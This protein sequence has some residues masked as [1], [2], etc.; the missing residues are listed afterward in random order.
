MRGLAASFATKLLRWYDRNRR[1]LP[2]R[3][4]VDAKQPPDPYR[5]MISEAMLQ[6]TQVAAV[7]P[8]FLRFL[9]QFPTVFDLAKA[10]DQEVLRLWQGL[11]YYS[12]ARN[13]HAAAK[14][15][16]DE[17]AGKIPRSPDVLLSL[18]G[19]GKYTAGAIASIAFD[20][21]APILDGNVIRVLCRLDRIES[22]PRSTETQKRLWQRAEEILPKRRCGDFNSALMELGATICT[23]R[24]PKCLLCP[25]RDHCQA[26]A[27]S[28]QEQI[29]APRKAT[30]TPLFHRKI[31]CIRHG[32]SFLIEQRPPKGRWA[33]MWQFVT[34][35]G[36][37]KTTPTY[38]K[39]HFAM[40]LSVVRSLG[41]VTHALTHRRYQFEAFI[42]D[43]R[44]NGKDPL[45]RRWATL[46]QLDAFPL[47][48]PHL[49]VAQ[50]LRKHGD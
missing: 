17:H 26:Q 30:P 3:V 19:V 31:L 27:A 50:M 15:I 28:V 47:P 24:S 1:D 22:D 20:C 46:D 42:C 12:R 29:P 34:L 18:P 11:G 43:V 7:I 25:V 37:V 5:V 38:L 49:K 32:N 45:P 23:P 4:P 48:L 36:E 8:Y 2:W 16:V 13:L 41:Q 10:E 14:R 40:N 39:K 9:E 44:R 33:G 35:D 21:R 6:Q